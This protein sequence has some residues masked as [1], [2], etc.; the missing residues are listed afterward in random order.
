MTL[1]SWPI[2]NLDLFQVQ[3]E[4]AEV[5][6]YQQQSIFLFSSFSKVPEKELAHKH[7]T[8]W[9]NQTKNFTI[10]CR[11]SALVSRFLQNW[12]RRANLIMDQS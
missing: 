8:N 6:L 2:H 5:F 4:K 10:W 9:L 1:H 11:K 12:R 7:K 3:E